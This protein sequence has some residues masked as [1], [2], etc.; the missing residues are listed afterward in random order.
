MKTTRRDFLLGGLSAGAAVPLGAS[1]APAWLQGATGAAGSGR[2]LVVVRVSGGYD[3]LNVIADVDHPVYNNARPNL[4]LQKAVTLPIDASTPRR[5]HPALLPFKQLY[6]RGELAVVQGVGYPQP[7]LSHFESEKIYYSADRNVVLVD[8]GWLG[9]Y[10]KVGYTGGSQL[11]ALDLEGALNPSF[12]GYQVPVVPNPTTFRFLSDTATPS[13]IDANTELAALR[14]NAALLRP[15]ADPELLYVANGIVSAY[16]NSQLIQTTGTTYSPSV[17]YPGTALGNTLRNAA[18][19]II[20]GLDTQIYFT[21]TGGLDTHANEVQA[22]ASEL[23]N[24]AARLADISGSIKALLDDVRN[25]GRGSDVVVLVWSEFGRRTG[26]NGS[27]GTD[28][29]HQNCAFVAGQPVMGGLYGRYPDLSLATTPYYNHYFGYVSGQ[30]TDFRSI[31]A[32]LLE[33][34]LLTPAQPILKAT[35]PLLPLL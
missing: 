34:W 11:P 18:R 13:N 23:G 35:Y 8:T 29:G 26:E 9:Q 25:Q 31:Y 1:L 10:L 5:F 32:T 2:V 19:F 27:L 7:N 3:W 30:T 12:N 24:L 22:G 20:G 33:K 4:R 17:T 28:H 16:D 15:T 6:D 21:S 14:A